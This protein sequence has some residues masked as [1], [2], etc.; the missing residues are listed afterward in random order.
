MYKLTNLKKLL[1]KDLFLHVLDLYDFINLFDD[2]K[3]Q[4]ENEKLKEQI[5]H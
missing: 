1:K 2:K 3:I 5:N 4:K